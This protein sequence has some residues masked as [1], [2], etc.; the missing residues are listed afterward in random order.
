MHERAGSIRH[1]HLSDLARQARSRLASVDHLRAEN[2]TI[3]QQSLKRLDE[4]R[5]LLDRALARADP[6]P[7]A[8]SAAPPA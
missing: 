3:R 7:A 1:E 5:A 8:G 4:S 6:S 2:T